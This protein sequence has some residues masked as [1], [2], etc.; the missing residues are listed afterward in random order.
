MASLVRKTISLREIVE[1]LAT[2]WPRLD[3][4]FL[5]GSRRFATGS[6]RSDLDLILV[7]VDETPSTTEIGEFVRDVSTY[8]DAFVLRERRLAQSAINNS[9]I[10]ATSKDEVSEEVGAVQVWSRSAGFVGEE[11]EVQEVLTDYVPVFTNAKLFGDRAADKEPIDFLV[12][13][14]LNDEFRAM[15]AAL[16]PHIVDRDMGIDMA[17]R[18]VLAKVTSGSK[19][20]REESVVLC[21]SDRKGNLASGLTTFDALNRWAPRLVILTGITAGLHGRSRIGDLLIADRVLDYEGSKVS[22]LRSRPHGVKPMLASAPIQRAMA[23]RGRDQA[24]RELDPSGGPGSLPNL[25]VVGY[26]SGEKVVA[27]RPRAW[28]FSRGDR[29]IAALEMESLGVADAC[30]RNRTD[31]FVL[32][33]VTDHADRRKGDDYRQYCCRIAAETVVRLIVDRVLLKPRT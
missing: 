33:A 15:E 21:Q 26:A 25:D 3:E 6:L 23:W 1:S 8:I 11:F 29:E 22:L 7:F 2:K 4:I 27:S 31:C 9:L 20:G 17:G 13:T 12:I 14:A 16:D 30:G 19:Q 24:L 18:Q 5:F 10:R 28:L 32:K